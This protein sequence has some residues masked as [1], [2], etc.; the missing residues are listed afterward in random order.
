M[1]FHP[2]GAELF[3]AGTEIDMTKLIVAFRHFANKPKNSEQLVSRPNYEDSTG[4]TRVRTP[5]TAVRHHF[6]FGVV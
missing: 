5:T 2:A 6:E 4:S 1:K 3:L